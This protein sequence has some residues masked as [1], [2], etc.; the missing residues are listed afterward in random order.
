MPNLHASAMTALLFASSILVCAGGPT[1]KIEAPTAGSAAAHVSYCRYDVDV[2]ALANP[3]SKIGNISGLR[4]ATCPFLARQRAP[5]RV[6]VS[7][8]ENCSAKD[9]RG[10]PIARVEPI[11]KIIND[12][13]LARCFPGGNSRSEPSSGDEAGIYLVEGS[14]GTDSKHDYAKSIGAIAFRAIGLAGLPIAHFQVRGSNSKVYVCLEMLR[15]ADLDPLSYIKLA[16]QSVPS[17]TLQHRLSDANCDA[18]F[19]KMGLE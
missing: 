12:R 6:Y 9:L 1:E 15:G 18:A 7:N 8:S 17:G 4:Y 16:G 5:A 11:T 2:S 10:L 14:I 3:Y 13:D 19:R